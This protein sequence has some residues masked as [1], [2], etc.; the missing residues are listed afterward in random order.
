MK[1][2]VYKGRAIGLGALEGYA[3]DTQ[4]LTYRLTPCDRPAGNK[5]KFIGYDAIALVNPH[6]SYEQAIIILN[7]AIELLKSDTSGAR[8]IVFPTHGKPRLVP[9]KIDLDWRVEKYYNDADWISDEAKRSKPECELIML[10]PEGLTQQA[11]LAAV[12]LIRRKV[13]SRGL[14][15]GMVALGYGLMATVYENSRGTYEMDY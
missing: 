11:R 5:A 2:K 1:N 14:P 9:L 3:V 6:L 13:K 12:R 7:R 4:R 10:F 8:S 15:K